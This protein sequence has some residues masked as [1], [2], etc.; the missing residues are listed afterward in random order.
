MQDC[1]AVSAPS[2]TKVTLVA[3]DGCSKKVD[4]VYYQSMVG[5][6]LYLAITTRPDITQAVSM[7]S[8]FDSNPTE[9]HMTAVK[10]IFRHLKGTMDL[11]LV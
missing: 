2:D 8:K 11:K 1:N 6:L 5:A 4:S 3:A 10:Q 7:V 9:T